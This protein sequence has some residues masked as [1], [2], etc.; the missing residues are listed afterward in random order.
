MFTG[1]GQMPQYFPI[2]HVAE[3]LDIPTSTL[4][5]WER[6]YKLFATT[7]RTAKGQRLYSSS[8]LEIALQ[9]KGYL[10]DGMRVRD[11]IL[12]LRRSGY[13]S[14]DYE[15]N[16]KSWDHNKEAV[17]LSIHDFEQKNMDK[18]IHSALTRYPEDY[19]MHKLI[20]PVFD[21]LGENWDKRPAGIAEERFASIY[22]L[23]KLGSTYNH[24]VINKKGVHVIACCLPDEQHEIGLL[25]FCLTI[26][27]RGFRPLIFS[28]NLPIDQY[29]TIIKKTDSKGIILSGKMEFN[30][31]TQSTIK[32]LA[33][34][35]KSSS[36]PV[37]VGG[38][39][40]VTSREK[41]QD[42]DIIP[43]GEN[44]EEAVGIIE[45]HISPKQSF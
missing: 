14:Q 32:N 38:K 27:Q 6:R 11:A 9:L 41:F 24:Q 3:L 21:Y 18:V 33:D 22:F 5:T 4:R 44:F 31:K 42:T 40:S 17:L 16:K 1:A 7:K 34:F 30:T 10:D 45:K 23:N 29:A 19:V 28:P 26:I 13:G 25:I 35:A 36:V 43:L 8:D 2:R 12:E 39:L 20:I 37:F 15:H